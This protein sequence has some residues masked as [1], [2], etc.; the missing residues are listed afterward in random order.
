MNRSLVARNT[1]PRA[2]LRVALVT[3]ASRRIGLGVAIARA[4]AERGYHI[5]VTARNGAQ[6]E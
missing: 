3:G 6:A 1:S 5:L 2:S 4:L